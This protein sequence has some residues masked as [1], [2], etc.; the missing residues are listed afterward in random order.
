M[1]FGGFE[2]DVEGYVLVTETDDDARLSYNFVCSRSTRLYLF[3]WFFSMSY[4][5]RSMQV[6]KPS[7]YTMVI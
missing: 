1:G 3:T 2:W 5:S 6:I 4:G 7:N